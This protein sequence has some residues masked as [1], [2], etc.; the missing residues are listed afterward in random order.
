MCGSYPSFFS[1]LMCGIAGYFGQNNISQNSIDST[2]GCLINRGPESY[3]NLSVRVST[4]IN[5]NLIFTRLAIIDLDSRAMQPLHYKNFILVLN[6]E[7]YNYKS[8]RTSI[9]TNYGPQIWESTG[10]VEVALRYIYYNGIKAIKDFDG[11]FAI[12]L[13]D[14]ENDNL[15]LARDY[16]GEKPLYVLK[17]EDGIYF[18]SEPKAIWGLQGKQNEVN[19]SK[20]VNFSLQIA[21]MLFEY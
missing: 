16:F 14:T 15:Y 10:D 12:A 13:F 1:D 21:N 7:I 2:L 3:N 8:L 4:K 19:K 20:I 6:G 18:G 9:E 17:T 11:M 5:L